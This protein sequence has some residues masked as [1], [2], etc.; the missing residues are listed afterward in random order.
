MRNT[1]FIL[2]LL[3]FV[4][5]KQSEKMPENSQNSKIEKSESD[6]REDQW[7]SLQQKYAEKRQEGISFYAFGENPHWEMTID[8]QNGL[9]FSSQSEFGDFDASDV[10]GFQP[11]D[12]NAIVY[13]AK[14][15]KGTL[16]AMVF[17]DTC[18]TEKGEKL[19]L[20]LSISGKKGEGS[21][22]EFKGCGLYLNN[23]SLHD[24]WAL[25]GWTALSANE[26]IEPGAYLEFNL[27]TQRLYGNLGC[28]EIEGNFSPMGDKIKIYGLDYRNTPCEKNESG[29]KIF[30]HLNYKTH[31]LSIHGLDLMLIHDQD[32]LRFL[33]A[34]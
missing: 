24:I 12:L 7:L 13:G 3:T 31:K 17:T 25:K 28:G 11:Q 33:K 1:L 5:C 22:A 6:L 8:E 16:S 20:R 26:Q 18:T 27:K 9:R 23:P 14:T 30:D 4:S 2:L 32:T 10:E 15:E 21:L 19:P 29:K 34:D